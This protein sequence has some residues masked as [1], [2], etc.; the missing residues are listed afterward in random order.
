MHM[1]QP[2]PQPEVRKEIRT[3]AAELMAAMDAEVEEKAQRFTDWM[4]KLRAAYCKAA[5]RGELNPSPR[6]SSPVRVL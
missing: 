1:S 6:P 4:L 2:P 3:Q 5:D